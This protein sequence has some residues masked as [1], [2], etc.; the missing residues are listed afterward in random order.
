MPHKLLLA[1]DSLTIQKVV[2]LVLTPENFEIKAVND[3]EAGWEAMSSFVPDIILA[4]IEMPKMNG[5]QLC[6]KIKNDMAYAQIPVILLAGAFEPFDEEYAKSV[7][8]DDFIIKPFE[9]QELI[10]KVKALIVNKE[11]AAP[12]A[13]A[14]EEPQPDEI[15]AASEDVQDTVSFTP[16]SEIEE[17]AAGGIRWD[18]EVPA[19]QEEKPEDVQPSAEE[20]Y[21]AESAPDMM[22]AVKGFDEELS[23]A[24]QTEERIESMPAEI[25][26]DVILS[27]IGSKVEEALNAVMPEI[28]DNIK[29]S[30]EKAV[31]EQSQAI[32][33]AVSRELI[34]GLLESL[35]GDIN[36][37]INRAVPE[38]AEAIIKKEIEKIT[39]EM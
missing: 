25:S 29:A 37:A 19:V 32:I 13:G 35:R 7:Y 15:E 22:S 24:M 20:E 21:E 23:E 9:S 27:V 1:D 3:G 31:S 26:A 34:S 6:E 4:D 2:E 36:A 17:E 5:Y 38:I 10:S 12:P 28:S 39:S 33:E 14:V 30:A 11:N 16:A 18:E 8:A